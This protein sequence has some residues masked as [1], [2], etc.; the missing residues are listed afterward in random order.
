[1]GLLFLEKITMKKICK[2]CKKWVPQGCPFEWNCS[3]GN[4]NVTKDYHEYK[5]NVFTLHKIFG[6]ITKIVNED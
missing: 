6:T 4:S 1:M 2:T 3:I 5:E